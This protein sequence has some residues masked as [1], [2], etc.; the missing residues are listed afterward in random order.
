M[1]HRASLWKILLACLACTLE[2]TLAPV[3]AKA[4]D[5]SLDSTRIA[6]TVESDGSLRVQET[7][8]L[9]FDDDINGVYWDI[10]RGTNQQGAAASVEITGVAEGG[11]ATDGA[12]S[13]D[14]AAKQFSRAA[15]ANVGDQGVY[16]VEDTGDAVKLKVFTPHESGDTT[17]LTVSYVLRGAVMAWKDTGELY[18]KFV[19]PGWSEDSRDVRMTLALAGATDSGVAATTGSAD[20]NLRAW[21]HGSLDGA[22][23]LDAQAA[24]V[25]FT[26][27]RVDSGQ[28]AE[29]R[30]AFPRA[31]VPQLKE[32]TAAKADGVDG[33][34]AR[35]PVILSEEKEWAEQANQQRAHARFLR[36]VLIVVGSVAPVV[37]FAV[38]VVVKLRH[39]KPVP[40]FQETYWRDVPS[41]DHP[42]VIAAFMNRGVTSKPGLVASIMQLVD[43]HVVAIERD[44]RE[45]LG[46]LGRKRQED[47]YFLSR[48]SPEAPSDAID[49]AALA[50]YLVDGHERVSMDEMKRMA[51]DDPEG[52]GERWQEFRDTVD[53]RY[54][55]RDLVASTGFAAIFLGSFGGAAAGV[56]SI[57]CAII[58]GSWIPVAFGVPLVAAGIV[59]CCTFRRFTPEGAELNAKCRALK[60]WLEEFTRLGEAVPGDVVLWNRLLVLAVALGVSERVLQELAAAT[61]ASYND[62]YDDGFYSAW[63][64]YTRHD[65]MADSPFASVNEVAG[66][67]LSELASSSDSSSGGFGGGFSSGGGEGVGGG[68]G[69][70]F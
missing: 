70:T 4:D 25:T 32:G 14:G 39:K 52:F 38:V 27:P 47:A 2:L 33:S 8:T 31:W 6:A 11:G 49:R 59:I 35:L 66:Y 9:S 26:A 12:G 5:Y 46:L 50:V 51:K 62:S 22:V 34:G 36:S 61:P 37:F 64:W 53:G 67:S 40:A 44:R 15:S 10:A 57:I 24:T 16:T 65:G 54:E 41:D 20:A 13:S 7:R 21:G 69:G 68:G 28:F 48:R 18:W 56:C 43:D 19:G 30:V 17:T 3:S 29:A 63:W 23:S 1:Q 58:G 45:V 55:E 60:R 42:A